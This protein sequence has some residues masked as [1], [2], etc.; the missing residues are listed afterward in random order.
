[1]EYWNIGDFYRWQIIDSAD[2]PQLEAY[3][4][5]WS[6]CQVSVVGQWKQESSFL[7]LR[8]MDPLGFYLRLSD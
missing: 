2:M 6:E 8:F 5:N 7:P 1:M 4:P 3:I